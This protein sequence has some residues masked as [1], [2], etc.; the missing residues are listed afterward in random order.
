M[1]SRRPFD[2]DEIRLALDAFRVAE[3]ATGDHF[4]LGSLE[5][6]RHAVDLRTLAELD[7][8]EVIPEGVLAQVTR[9]D[10]RDTIASHA[11]TLYRICLQDHAIL[12]RLWAEKG[13]VE[14]FP[15]LVYVL[16]HELVHVVRFLGHQ[17]GYLAPD[18]VRSTEEQRV[19][20]A[21]ERILRRVPIRGLPAVI[22][23]FRA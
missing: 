12:S 2:P 20:E 19:Q 18:H 4:A 10:E 11:R 7:S 16:T 3:D 22:D 5:S 17:T 14:L 9:W 21:T 13:R 8:P 6:E 1:G 23:R 15:L